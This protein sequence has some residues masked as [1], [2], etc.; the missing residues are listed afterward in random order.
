MELTG[1]NL[2]PREHV[3]KPPNE[4]GSGIAATVTTDKNAEAA[5]E[6]ASAAKEQVAV[7]L[8]E[9]QQA[10]DSI[11]KYLESAPR[12]LQIAITDNLA[13]P[14]FTVIDG[15]TK[16]VVR[17]IP[18]EEVVAIARFLDSYNWPDPENKTWLPGLL[19]DEMS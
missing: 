1:V 6:S 5:A 14:I 7:D 10:V 18:S 4:S 3:S 12:D 16:E 2:G 15:E 13:R 9:V 8:S 11:G 19:V 17:Q